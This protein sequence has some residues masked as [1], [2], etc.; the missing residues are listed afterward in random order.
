MNYLFFVVKNAIEDFKKNKTQTFLTSLGI[1]I[2]VFAVVML[3]ALG[4]GLKKYIN[5]QFAQLGKNTLFIV[6]GKII[7]GGSFNVA[8]TLQSVKFDNRDLARIRKLRGVEE[9][10]PIYSAQTQVKSS[11]G[12]EE[13]TIIFSNEA[14][15]EINGF[16]IKIGRFFDQNEVIKRSKVVVLGSKIAEKLFGKPDL[17]VN[18]RLSV[19]RISYTVIGVI[20]PEGGGGFGGPDYDNYLF[21]PYTTGYI[22]NPQKDFSR[23]ALQFDDE[24]FTLQEIKDSIIREMLKRHNDD[25][26]SLIEPGEILRAVNSIFSI[27]NFVLVAIASISLVVGGIGIMNIMFVTVTEKTREIG[28]RRAIGARKKDILFQF[29][30]ESTLLSLFGG[31]IGLGLAF[32]LTLL[33]QRFIPAYIDIY[34]VLLALGVSSFVGII[35]GVFPAKKAAD[36]SP[37]EAIRYQ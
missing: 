12:S 15:F 21:A 13:G 2:G 8:A 30:V 29:I 18:Q 34:S 26:F 22:F 20:E 4:L 17:A 24:K 7:Q 31:S 35:F 16:K 3:M 11:K 19:S 27:L 6:P 36:L 9:V 37:I 23:I 33:V 28:I 25:S 32:L 1:M 14:F 5:D 10:A